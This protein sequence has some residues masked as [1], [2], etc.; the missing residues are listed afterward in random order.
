STDV[1]EATASWYVPPLA[2]AWNGARPTVSGRFGPLV[3]SPGQF[4]TG[5][6]WLPVV[7]TMIPP[8]T[9]KP[10]CS[11]VSVDSSVAPSG[12]V[13][14]NVHAPSGRMVGWF[15]VRVGGQPPLVRYAADAVGKPFGSITVASAL[16][17]D[18]WVDA[19][20]YAPGTNS[21]ARTRP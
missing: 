14:A 7:D 1:V 12:L 16:A 10:R 17:V 8:L 6:A 3:A 5:A 18:T 2:A 15:A 19:A 9:W 13:T 4:R 21:E 20:A 11:A